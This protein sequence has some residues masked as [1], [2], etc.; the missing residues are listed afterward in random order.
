MSLRAQITT[1]G[2]TSSRWQTPQPLQPNR[3]L[4]VLSGHSHI[5]INPAP[6]ANTKHTTS[7]VSMAKDRSVSGCVRHGRQIK[8]TRVSEKTKD[9]FPRISG[10][11]FL[12]PGL[13]EFDIKMLG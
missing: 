11:W 12:H 4:A 7:L 13:A 6:S 1:K 3:T 9:S 8:P 10:I 5:I 2:A